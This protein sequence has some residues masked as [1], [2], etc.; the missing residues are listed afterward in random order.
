MPSK[1]TTFDNMTDTE[2]QEQPKIK[3]PPVLFSKTQTVIKNV[4]ALLGGP[5]VCYWNNERG[6]VCS[7]DVLA[8]YEVLEK[9]GQHETI[10]FF[11][12]SDGGSGQV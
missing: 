1:L 12:K 3:Q 10:Y 8:L 5:L 4:S 6:S 2:K 9:L 11:I 7:N